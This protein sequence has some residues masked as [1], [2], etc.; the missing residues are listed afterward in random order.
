[1]LLNMEYYLYLNNE[2]RGPYTAGQLRSMWQTGTL[3]THTLYRQGSAPELFE[4]SKIAHLLDSSSSSLQLPE[5]KPSPL[6]PAEV[7]A[8]AAPSGRRF[9][10]FMIDYVS[11]SMIA[12]AGIF[13]IMNGNKSVGIWLFTLGWT[14]CIYKDAFWRGRSVGKRLLGLVIVS[15]RTGLPIGRLRA[16]WRGAAF[17]V[18]YVTL[19]LPVIVIFAIGHDGRGLINFG[20]IPLL[21]IVIEGL[22]ALIR[23]DGRRVVDFF[24]GTY[25]ALDQKVA[26]AGPIP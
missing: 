15:R 3:T 4:L 2:Q 8:N 17:F 24:A 16:L 22:L 20:I 21:P 25:V 18:A 1:M 26:S 14:Y 7:I 23:S 6:T 19:L 13:A 11:A 10:A 9:L 5:P 12:F